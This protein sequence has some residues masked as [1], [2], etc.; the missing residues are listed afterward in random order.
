MALCVGDSGFEARPNAVL[1]RDS[2]RTSVFVFIQTT[3]TVLSG[4]DRVSRWSYVAAILVSTLGHIL[5]FFVIL[6]VLPD[7]FSS[8]P[9]PPSYTVKIVDALPAGELGTHLPQLNQEAVEH[10]VEHHK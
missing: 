1:I 5:F 9:P 10:H 7:L 2:R 8:K 4:D 6:V 3:A